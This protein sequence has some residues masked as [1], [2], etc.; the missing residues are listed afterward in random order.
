MVT[1]GA[2]VRKCVLLLTTLFLTIQFLALTASAIFYAFT[3]SEVHRNKLEKFV[4]TR[5]YDKS[6][7]QWLHESKALSLHVLIAMV[8]QILLLFPTLLLII[9]ASKRMRFLLLPWLIIYGILQLCLLAGMFLSVTHLT[10]EM[11]F[12]CLV[13]AALEVLI[14]FPW[15]F[16]VIHMFAVFSNQDEA[17]DLGVAYFNDR[18]SLGQC[19]ATTRFSEI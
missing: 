12:L 8:I 6:Q 9:G 14:V 3:N 17:E 5:I 10:D 16:S 19:S 13:F 1:Q 11:K 2:N 15:W 7:W 4:F 18:H